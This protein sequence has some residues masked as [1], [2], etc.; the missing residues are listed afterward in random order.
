MQPHA[1]TPEGLHGISP[2]AHVVHPGSP[3]L[4]QPRQLPAAHSLLL[5][6]GLHSVLPVQV[7]THEAPLSESSHL[8]K[9]EQEG[10]ALLAASSP[11]PAGTQDVV[12]EHLAKSMRPLGTITI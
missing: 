7:P 11:L 9:V 2:A 1:H 4:A 5:P 12:P 3:G 10:H 6:P 8:L